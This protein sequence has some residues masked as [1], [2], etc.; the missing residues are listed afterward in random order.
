MT[1]FEKITS[2]LLMALALA[3]LSACGKDEAAKP[4]EGTAS[5]A[6]AKPSLTVELIKP[7]A[8]AWPLMAT[9]HGS[10]MPWQEA[11]IGAE[12]NGLRVTE[13]LVNVGDWVKKGQV[14]VT[15]HKEG[16]TT[17]VT[18]TRAQ[19]VEAVA[20]LAEARTNATRA[21]KL[22]QEDAISDADA[23]RAFTAEQ[24]AQ[25]RVDAL[26]A[27]MSG[28]EI[29]MAQSVVTAPDDGIIS[30]RMATVGSVLQ[31]MPGQ[32]LF[33]LIRQGRL[34][35][36]GEVPSAELIQVKPGMLAKV[37]AAG[38]AEVTGRVR[39]VGPTVD[40]TTR[41]GLV[42]VDLATEAAQAA[43][44]K[45]GMFAKGVL[46]MGTTPSLSLPQSAVLLRDGYSYVMR[47]DGAGKVAE[48]KIKVGRRQGDRI[49]ILEGLSPDEP[50]IASGLGFLTDGDTV[51]VV[52][53]G[54]KR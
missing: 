47:V 10:I 7:Q 44:I 1:R 34:E 12:A 50:V 8:S 27:Q 53:H 15:M 18:A 17:E 48:H 21:R 42:Y 26:K 45:A 9:A 36:R 4:A 31:P 37:S 40:I 38:G 49:E 24:Q 13:V 19:W 23:Q 16:L 6:K 43:G 28:S 52:Q 51:S 11:V 20:V 29:R 33:R 5:Q 3:G 41:N 14:L 25:A 46:S 39:M 2:V 54:A 30:A 35:W 22:K 32:E